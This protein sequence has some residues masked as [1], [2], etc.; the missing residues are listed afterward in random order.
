MHIYHI[1]TYTDT[2]THTY[3]HITKS[4]CCT[5]ESNTTFKIN[6]T[7][8]RKKKKNRNLFL[9]VLEAGSPRLRHWQI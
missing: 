6:Y 7:S 1:H 4:L 9:P 2:H 5:P 8:I 3:I